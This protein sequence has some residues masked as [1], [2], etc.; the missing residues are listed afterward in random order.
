MAYKTFR[1]NEESSSDIIEAELIKAANGNLILELNGN[2]VVII[3]RD[4][5]I[6]TDTLYTINGNEEARV[7][8]ESI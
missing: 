1:L 3:R 6:D 8:W 4:G 2:D 7:N 5:T